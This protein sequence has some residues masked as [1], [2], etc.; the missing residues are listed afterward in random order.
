[1]RVSA[2]RW[3]A[4]GKASNYIKQA[5]IKP[6]DKVVLVCRVSQREQ[7]QR[8]NLEDQEA[9]LRAEVAALDGIVVGVTHIQVSGFDPF[10][11]S[12][13]VTIAQQHGAKLLAE[14]T[15]R[16]VRHPAFNSSKNNS[17]NARE[18]DLRELVA[19]AEGVPLVTLLHPDA[20]PQEVR[21]YQRKRG[22]RIK[23]AKGGRPERPKNRKVRLI[24]T[25][26]QMRED[27][28]SWGEIAL[29]LEVPR[30]TVARWCRGV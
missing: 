21:S 26:T 9:N 27:G 20:T 11:I 14:S 23:Q 17:R 28:A 4:C 7:K 13:A 25:A 16:F 6:G 30:S 22:Q 29:A 1:M 8:K 24:G 18:S 3:L 15:D 12:R 5:N 19:C 10:W 2:R